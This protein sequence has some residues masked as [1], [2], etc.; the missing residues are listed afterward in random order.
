MEMKT[1]IILMTHG[2]FGKELIASGAL[3]LGELKDVFSISLEAEREPMELMAELKTLLEKD[4]DQ[5]LILA[6]LFGGTPCNVAA[7]FSLE[8][9]VI[10]LS[11]VNLPMLVEAEMA[12]M[13]GNYDGLTEKLMTS[14]TEGIK[15]VKKIMQ[16]RKGEK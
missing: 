5:Y 14:A 6:D 15:D 9:N 13:Q 10:V 12:R 3:I 2:S 8:E 4:F 11:G 7:R 16:E 1:A